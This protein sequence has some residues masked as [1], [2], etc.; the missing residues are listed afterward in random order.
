[1]GIF[2]GFSRMS[3]LAGKEWGRS[4]RS[5]E[6]SWEHRYKW[7]ECHEIFHRQPNAWLSWGYLSPTKKKICVFSAKKSGRIVEPG[8]KQQWVNNYVQPSS[9]DH[10]VLEVKSKVCFCLFLS[11]SLS[12]SPHFFTKSGK[13]MGKGGF[14]PHQHR[15]EVAP[16][17]VLFVLFP[18]KISE[19]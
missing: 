10:P 4:K 11:I 16:L 15:F 5:M 19:I 14:P 18:V 1:M 3:L 12:F 2:R 9:L 8:R 13:K 17:F 7:I 6:P